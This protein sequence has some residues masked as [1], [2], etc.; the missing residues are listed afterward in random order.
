MHCKKCK[1]AIYYL[2]T[3]SENCIPVDAASLTYQEISAIIGKMEVKFD[4]NKH[5][6]HYNTC[7]FH[8]PIKKWKH[9]RINPILPIQTPKKK[10]EKPKVKGTSKAKTRPVIIRRKVRIKKKK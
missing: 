4:A 7:P 1:K 8:V 10:K 6:V 2:K 9:K 3:D 5:I